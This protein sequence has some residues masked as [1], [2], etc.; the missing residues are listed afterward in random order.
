MATYEQNIPVDFEAEL[1]SKTLMN[2]YKTKLIIPDTDT[3]LPDPFSLKDGW[4]SESK[5]SGLQHWPSVYFMDID[6][7]LQKVNFSSD[8]MCRLK[9]E[10]KEGKA[11]GVSNVIG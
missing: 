5:D 1:R 7:Y 9:S 11:F 2:E 8:L 3:V 10:Y 6:K 4:L